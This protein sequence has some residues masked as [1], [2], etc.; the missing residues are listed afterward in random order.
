MTVHGTATG[1]TIITRPVSLGLGFHIKHVVLG[2]LFTGGIWLFTG[3]PLAIHSARRRM[4]R[5]ST[6][7]AAPMAPPFAP[8]F[9]QASPLVGDRRNWPGTMVPP[10]G[11][12]ILGPS[13]DQPGN[14]VI[15]YDPVGADGQHYAWGTRVSA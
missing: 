1:R 13:T 9:A 6:E 14:M 5:V 8:G 11:W 3:Y 10:A 7:Y 4:T 2:V 12:A 15:Q